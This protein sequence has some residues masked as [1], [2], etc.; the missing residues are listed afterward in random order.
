MGLFIRMS[1]VIQSEFKNMLRKTEEPED[2]LHE[3]INDLEIQGKEIR[4]KIKNKKASSEKDKLEEELNN[5]EQKVEE[6]KSRKDF[7]LSRKKRMEAQKN[8]LSAMED[9][10]DISRYDK[11]VKRE[12]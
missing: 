5:I 8:I 11:L 6:A 7:Y 9:M 3:L 10:D 12:G 1:K 2:M 4:D